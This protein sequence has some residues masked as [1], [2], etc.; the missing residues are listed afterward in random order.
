MMARLVA[1]EG[2]RD[3][4]LEILASIVA[5]RRDEIAA[6][7]R[8]LR[9]ELLVGAG[10]LSAALAELRLLTTELSVYTDFAEQGLLLLGTVYEQLTNYT[11]ARETYTRLIGE[12]SDAKVK[13]EAEAR[14]K[15]L[16]K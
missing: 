11:A 8:L 7:A 16:K 9:S 14:L 1:R 12:T 3:L 4:G 2:D 10:D 5:R 13:A 6:E 15:R